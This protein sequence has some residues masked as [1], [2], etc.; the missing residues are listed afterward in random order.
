[1]VFSDIRK[2]NRV[3][4]AYLKPSDYCSVGC[5]HCYLPD[6]ART[7]RVRMTLNTLD[8]AIETIRGMASV[9]PARG[10][11]IVW[12]GGEPLALPKE[13]F[14]KMCERVRERLPEAIQSIQTSLI[15]YRKD[16]APILLEFTGTH[17]G[18][19]I[20]FS[21]RT[22][23][24]NAERY[25]LLWLKKAAQ[26]RQDGFSVTPGVVPS[27]HELGRGIEICDWME[28][29]GFLD[30]N[31][32]RYN[33]HGKE[34]LLRPSNIE[35]SEFLTQVFKAAM[36]RVERGVF[37][38]INTVRAALA[39]IL[40]GATG[41]RWGTSCSRDFIVVNPDGTASACPDMAGY[42]SYGHV[43]GGFWEFSGSEARRK[44]IR[45]HLIG[46]ANPNCRSCRFNGFCRTGCPLTPNAPELEGD[47]S[48]YSRHL[49]HVADFAVRK[50]DIAWKYLRETTE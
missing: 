47:C 43:S 42:S 23:R 7:S 21:L 24:G 44:W 22:I 29:H 41:D 1:M 17:I 15:P 9:Q 26:A 40:V 45:N 34:D 25:Q 37:M 50:P 19:S 33:S 14:R 46:R 13:Y 10:I 28:R 8:K 36:K 20:D 3:V 39:G 32:D 30:W 2:N 5:E 18:S 4:T 6:E 27:R 31:I 11:L 35:H 12:H 49:S 16:W 48:G 38:K